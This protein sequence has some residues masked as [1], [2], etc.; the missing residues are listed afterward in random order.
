M[1]HGMQ[2]HWRAQYLQ[3]VNGTTTTRQQEQ[4][5]RKEWA[6]TQRVG[7]LGNILAIVTGKLT[8]APNRGAAAEGLLA[9]GSVAGRSG[10]IRLC[11]SNR[12]RP[13]RR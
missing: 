5:K 13:R 9:T 3:T 12:G 2:V 11:P 7:G 4:L 1:R 6:E 8:Q 10:G